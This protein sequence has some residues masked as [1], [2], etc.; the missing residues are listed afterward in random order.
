MVPVVSLEAAHEVA[1]VLMQ[2]E[3]VTLELP[4]AFAAPIEDIT[5]VAKIGVPALDAHLALKPD[6]VLRGPAEGGP[7]RVPANAR[8]ADA[9]KRVVEENREL[10]LIDNPVHLSGVPREPQLLV[11]LVVIAD[12]RTQG[13]TPLQLMRLVNKNDVEAFALARLVAHR[14]LHEVTR[15]DD[16]GLLE[17]AHVS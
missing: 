9:L 10:C 11:H 15:A 14:G 4:K 2:L 17:P 7:H 16:V 12:R 8:W 1:K 6:G 5:D 13:N 3:V